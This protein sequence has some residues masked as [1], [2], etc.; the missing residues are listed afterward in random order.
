MRKYLKNLKNEIIDLIKG[1]YISNGIVFLRK[2]I[3]VIIIM[4]E[5]GFVPTRRNFFFFEPPTTW[6]PAKST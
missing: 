3:W 6:P 1:Y 5:G 4:G 2:R